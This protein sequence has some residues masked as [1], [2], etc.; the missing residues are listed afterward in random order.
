MLSRLFGGGGSG[1][2]SR[3]SIAA[4]PA[5][6][7][8]AHLEALHLTL[9]K[10]R[11]FSAAAFAA[12]DKAG[13][14][15]G[16]SS[17]AVAKG[18]TFGY[19]ASVVV[20]TL[21]QISELMV[22]GDKNNAE[23]FFEVFCERNMLRTFVDLFQE[24]GGAH[25]NPRHDEVRVQ[26][27]QTVSI[28]LMNIANQRSLFY[29][30]SNNFV[31]EL[32]SSPFDMNHE[33]L[34][35]YYISLLKTL[36]L[37]FNRD[38][39][40][41]FYYRSVQKKNASEQI[42]TESFPLY[43][44]AVRLYSNE[45]SMVRTA[46][47]AIT[48]NVFN[49]ADSSLRKFLTKGEHSSYPEQLALHLRASII[50]LSKAVSEWHV[51]TVFG[52][53]KTTTST[54]NCVIS[55]KETVLKDEESN[56]AEGEPGNARNSSSHRSHSAAWTPKVFEFLDLIPVTQ[57]LIDANYGK[58]QSSNKTTTTTTIDGNREKENPFS[59]SSTST[60]TSRVREEPT[61]QRPRKSLDHARAE[62]GTL[63]SNVLDECFYLQDVLT[64]G[65][66]E[67]E[68]KAQK[69]S[70]ATSASLSMADTTTSPTTPV[71]QQETQSS[72]TPSKSKSPRSPEVDDGG[73]I[74]PITDAVCDYLISH[75][76]VA[77]ILPSWRRNGG[78][79]G[80]E[81]PSSASKSPSFA[82]IDPGVAMLVLA[83]MLQIFR[84]KRL[85]TWLER[86]L[87]HDHYSSSVSSNAVNGEVKLLSSPHSWTPATLREAAMG[88]ILS[89]DQRLSG[90][91]LL[92]LRSM[93]KMPLV[94]PSSL[95]A[96]GLLPRARWAK[97]TASTAAAAATAAI[98]TNQE[99]NGAGSIN[100]LRPP[101]VP[102]H[103]MS[104]M[105]QLQHIGTP[106]SISNSSS[107]SSSSSSL[108][109]SGA[110]QSSP[111]RNRSSTVNYSASSTPAPKAAN[112]GGIKDASG[113][114]S[115][116]GKSSSA[117]SEPDV[118]AD[119]QIGI[120]SLRKAHPN[121]HHVQNNSSFSQGVNG[122]D[123]DSLFFQLPDEDATLQQAKTE[124]TVSVL[125]V[126][127]S[128]DP[129]P[130]PANLTLA[131]TLLLELVYIPPP[132]PSLTSLV[133]LQ[134]APTFSPNQIVLLRKACSSLGKAVSHPVTT[135]YNDADGNLLLRLLAVAE[136]AA[137]DEARNS[138]V[139]SLC[140]KATIDHMQMPPHCE[141]PFSQE[142][143]K[144]LSQNA[145]HAKHGS[146]CK[147]SAVLT[148]MSAK[149][150]HMSTSSLS[151]PETVDFLLPTVPCPKSAFWFEFELGVAE[152]GGGEG[153]GMNGG[154]SKRHHPLQSN[155]IFE[156]KTT[157]AVVDALAAACRP[158]YRTPTHAMNVTLMS[159]TPGIKMDA[160][161]MQPL[162]LDFAVTLQQLL[163]LRSLLLGVEGESFS[164]LIRAAY[165]SSSTSSS[166]S[167]DASSFASVSSAGS[168]S[169]LGELEMEDL[170]CGVW[171]VD[172][173]VREIA[174]PLDG[175]AAGNTFSLTNLP[176][177]QA[178]HFPVFL[179]PGV[180]TANATVIMQGALES[181][182][183]LGVV[184]G[185]S[186]LVL[187]DVLTSSSNLQ[188]PKTSPTNAT[189]GSSEHPAL[190]SSGNSSNN[191]V[192]GASQSPVKVKGKALLVIPLHLVSLH[193]IS[194]PES[195]PAI[196]DVRF[197]S[198]SSISGLA[199]E[200]TDSPAHSAES[201]WSAAATTSSS[202]PLP[203]PRRYGFALALES[204]EVAARAIEHVTV[205]SSRAVTMKVSAFEKLANYSIV[206]SG[207]TSGGGGGGGNGG[208]GDLPP[209]PQKRQVELVTS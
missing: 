177:F 66:S 29:L 85:S 28:L 196:L 94:S 79:G 35:G 89:R 190:G 76:L 60:T 151:S 105:Q 73:S 194:S 27:L 200:A 204:P 46:V 20:E 202:T 38:T 53:Q 107:S 191:A 93:L 170:A 80:G 161:S 171:C 185:Q 163:V 84:Y 118:T 187:T 12:S 162:V 64:I 30:L 207:S 114:A 83:N 9:T 178:T 120:R 86:A 176:W 134:Q 172:P 136:S 36:S 102:H 58:Q 148:A 165:S 205:A 181:R 87:F 158:P 164:K 116:R 122:L 10:Q 74:L 209:V 15:S 40:Q 139:Q 69:A 186:F 52:M 125:L 33:E 34:L 62:I 54:S 203:R 41:F 32:I 137:E 106:S 101:L 168:S 135:A 130:R 133:L 121:I 188:Q 150:S 67:I 7:S 113:Y 156:G 24:G 129:P 26:V 140:A 50:K 14:A 180:S 153:E 43:T 149:G 71:R 75:V 56:S 59:S 199:A 198:G 82:I 141:I 77:V 189:N 19:D 6:F 1:G 157:V 182:R 173:I 111:S 72:A 108:Q 45:E 78:R 98:S 55:S 44:Q 145:F 23:R 2:G 100:S 47:R 8:I 39:I 147:S 195:S 127:L 128:S 57:E 91:A 95:A 5:P 159:V 192:N 193:L 126:V 166:S 167:I 90:C 92:A 109:Q 11:A 132:L 201:L 117:A 197:I 184:L 63:L 179:P 68:S 144:L 131:L 143:G 146:Q 175:I 21:K 160:R 31:N 3:P 138:L 37:S 152:G 119:V 112:G 183:R 97:L 48:L 103:S 65:Q 169:T 17:S 154:G 174:P 124:E 4:T 70:S 13:G 99:S 61:A 142:D 51:T 81:V 155:D 25:G 208:S 110:L 42:A 22:Y 88:L 123:E 18:A 115:G 16:A 96:V 206:R 49:T 104:T